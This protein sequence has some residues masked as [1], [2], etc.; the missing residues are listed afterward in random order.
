VLI[1]DDDAGVRESTAELLRVAGYGVIEAA[2]GIEGLQQLRRSEPVDA[3]L[4]DLRM[5]GIDGIGVLEA[6]DVHPPVIVVSAFEYFTQQ[7]VTE[8]FGAKVSA[9]LHK[10]V[11]PQQLLEVVAETAGRG[12]DQA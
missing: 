1:I 4:L 8:R 7:E 2:D 11:P 3:V 6:V 9:V 10:P 12:R 5:P